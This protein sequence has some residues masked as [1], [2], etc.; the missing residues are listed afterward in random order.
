MDV[1]KQF[2]MSVPGLDTE[3]WFARLRCNIHSGSHLASATGI[4]KRGGRVWVLIERL[5]NLTHVRP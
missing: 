2:Q 5:D 3:I 1:C 4:L